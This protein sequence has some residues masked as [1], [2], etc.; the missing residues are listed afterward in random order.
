MTNLCSSNV[1]HVGLGWNLPQYTESDCSG[2]RKRVQRAWEEETGP[3]KLVPVIGTL[4]RVSL[5]KVTA[6]LYPPWTDESSFVRAQVT[7]GLSDLKPPSA[8]A[9]CKFSG[10]EW[11]NYRGIRAKDRS[12]QKYLFSVWCFSLLETVAKIPRK[13][14]SSWDGLKDRSR[15]VALA[16]RCFGDSVLLCSSV[17]SQR[18]SPHPY[19]I[20]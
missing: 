15:R 18:A 7:E 16:L 20:Q 8:A 9:F 14:F 6:I 1:K 11:S 2:S 10:K 19:K 13:I 12:R 3:S 4:D 17:V 5:Q